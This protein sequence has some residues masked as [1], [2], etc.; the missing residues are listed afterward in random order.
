MRPP[1]ERLSPP[2]PSAPGRE[3]REAIWRR[4][5]LLWDAVC[6]AAHR[7]RTV[8]TMRTLGLYTCVVLVKQGKLLHRPHYTQGA[9]VHTQD[10]SETRGEGCESRARSAC[11]FIARASSLNPLIYSKATQGDSCRCHWRQP[12]PGVRS[13]V[14]LLHCVE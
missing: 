5:S 10:N 8:G 12:F 14:V 6:T 2:D 1:V 4:V 13:R 9:G 11:V 3:S 7:T